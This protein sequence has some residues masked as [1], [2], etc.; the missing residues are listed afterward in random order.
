LKC[1]YPTALKSEASRQALGKARHEAEML[2]KCDPSLLL[3]FEPGGTQWCMSYCW[4][5]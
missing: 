4:D 2:L 1:S 5:W 3:L